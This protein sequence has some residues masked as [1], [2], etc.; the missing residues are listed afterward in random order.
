MVISRQGIGTRDVRVL[1]RL[2]LRSLPFVDAAY[3][4]T[5]LRCV[6]RAGKRVQSTP[7]VQSP[8]SDPGSQR[9]ACNASSRG[10]RIDSPR[11]LTRAYKTGTT[12]SVKTVEDSIPP[13]IGAAMR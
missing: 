13:T 2:T 6:A 9:D 4:H 11:L 1:D 7:H 8:I 12:A 10:T 3:A 5:K